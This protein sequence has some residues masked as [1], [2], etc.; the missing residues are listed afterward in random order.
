MRH[1]RTLRRLAPLA[2]LLILFILTGCNKQCQCIGYDGSRVTYS[3]EELDARG[4]TCSEM[5]IHEGL[6]TRLYSICE[7]KN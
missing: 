1:N 2:L 5:V 6:A 3:E 4:K 7:W